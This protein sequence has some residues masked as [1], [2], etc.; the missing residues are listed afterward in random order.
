MKFKQELVNRKGRGDVSVSQE[1]YA[2]GA[3]AREERGIH[4]GRGQFRG[5][6][7]NTWGG[8]GGGHSRGVL[9]GTFST[10]LRSCLGLAHLASVDV[11]CVSVD[12]DC[13]SVDVDCVSVDVDCVSVDVDCVSVDVDCV[14]VDVDCVCRC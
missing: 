14:S 8:G 3:C 6:F 13:V 4:G 10:V 12:V 11:D 1:H 7:S 2:P 9:A 5:T